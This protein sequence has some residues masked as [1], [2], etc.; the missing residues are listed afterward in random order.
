MAP[1]QG[2]RRRYWGIVTPLPTPVIAMLAQQAEAQGLEG[3]FAPQVLGPPW[4]SLAVAAAHTQRIKVASGIAIAAARSPFE[5]AMAAIDMDRISEGRFILGLGA[6]VQSWTCGVFGAPPHKPITHLRETVA[7]VRHIIRGAHTGLEP[8]EGQYYKGDYSALQ[9][10]QPPLREEIPIW[11]AALR[12][13]AVRLAAEVADGIMG[14]PIWSVDWAM[15]RIQPEIAAG[16]ERAGRKRQ[17]VELNLWF[18][19]APNTDEKEAIEDARTTVGFY[20][21]FEQY[22]SFFAAHGFRDEARRAQEIARERDLFVR[23]DLVPDEMVRTF[24]LCGKPESVRERIE[25]AWT[26]ADSLCVLPPAYG[27]E[28]EKMMHY[29]TEIAKLSN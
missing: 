4:S 12:G 28:P 6:S 11:L 5:T 15:E 2:Q 27:L 10:L 16:L 14:H 13:P 20:A 7:A 24:V 19:C 26:V 22:E 8:F 1:E 25:R 3:V 21:A 9:P 29:H 18:W 17:D 23:R